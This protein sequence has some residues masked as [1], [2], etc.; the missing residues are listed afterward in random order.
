MDLNDE[1][2]AQQWYA[3]AEHSY[4]ECHQGCP[5]CHRRHCVF[6]ACWGAR[7]EYYC[8]ACDF[9]ASHDGQTGRYFTAPGDGRQLAE[10]LLSASSAENGR[11]I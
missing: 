4:V 2:M 9:S 5:S 10:A 6:R 3:Q 8:S 11:L 1:P 7:T